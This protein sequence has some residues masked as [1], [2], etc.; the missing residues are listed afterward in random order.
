MNITYVWH[1]FRYR[2]KKVKLF[3]FFHLYSKLVGGFSHLEKYESQW[4]GLSHILWSIIQMFETTDQKAFWS[5]KKKRSELTRRDVIFSDGSMTLSSAISEVTWVGPLSALPSK[6]VE[7]T[8]LEH[9]AGWTNVSLGVPRGHGNT[10]SYI[11]Q[12]VLWFIIQHYKPTSPGQHLVPR[13]HWWKSQGW[14]GTCDRLFCK[15]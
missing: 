10:V 12:L 6:G 2:W 11:I 13:S 15:H 3:C 9:P 7:C 8:W 5:W 14:E 1:I 4:E